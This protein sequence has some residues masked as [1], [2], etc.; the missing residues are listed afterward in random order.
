MLRA[1]LIIFTAMFSVIILKMKLFKHH[2]FSLMLIIVGLVLVGLSQALENTD[3]D[4]DANN[5][6]K[7]AVGKMIVGVIV[8]LIGQVLGALSYIFEEKFLAD[9]DDVHP[10]IV[11]AWEG[12]WGTLIVGVMLV[13]MQFIPCSN[14]DLCSPSGVIEDSYSAVIELGTSQPQIIF[15]ILLILLAGIYNTAGTSVIAYGSAAARCT[16]EQLR[17]ALVWIY[18]MIFYVNGRR[19]EKFTVLQLVGFIVLFFGIMVFNEMIVLPVFAK[20]T[21]YERP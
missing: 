16:I 12:I 13:M 6:T 21:R 1:T 5:K 4:P 14:K 19:L 11:V 17:N 20:D 15:T 7:D 3:P 9:Y 2:Y 8:L 18:F 10:L